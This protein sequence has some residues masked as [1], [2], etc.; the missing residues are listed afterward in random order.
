MDLGEARVELGVTVAARDDPEIDGADREEVARELNLAPPIGGVCDVVQLAKDVEGTSPVR[1][2][3]VTQRVQPRA[4]ELRVRDGRGED[5]E[6]GDTGV[7]EHGLPYLKLRAD[8][9][10]ADSRKPTVALS[11]IEPPL[12]VQRWSIRPQ[13]HGRLDHPGIPV[14]D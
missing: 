12:T 13:G 8:G 2:E 1:R 4:L 11:S 3:L 10:S 14:Y 6:Q 9:I 7:A 5:D